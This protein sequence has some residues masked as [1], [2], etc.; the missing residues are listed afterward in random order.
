MTP[1][2]TAHLSG[3]RKRAL[4]QARLRENEEMGRLQVPLKA[5]F[6]SRQCR[7]RR[8]GPKVRLSRDQK[9]V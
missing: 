6:S 5:R 1:P 7:P 3:P 9:I 2:S 8:I 4:S